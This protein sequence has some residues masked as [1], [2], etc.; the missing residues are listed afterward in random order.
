MT[1]LELDAGAQP[2]CPD[3]KVVMR[4]VDGGSECP[5]CGYFEPHDEV[6]M[7]PDFD[8]PDIHDR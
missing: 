4:D 7:P 3:C 2:R 1:Y 6:V 5:V 8:G